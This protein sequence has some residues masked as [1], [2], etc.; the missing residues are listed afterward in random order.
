ML[1]QSV[2]RDGQQRS[3][4]HSH[5]ESALD[6]LAE[7]APPTTPLGIGG[8]SR[9]SGGG[10][11]GGGSGGCSGSDAALVLWDF[12]DLGDVSLSKRST[13]TRGGPANRLQ[14]PRENHMS[15]PSDQVACKT[16]RGA[17]VP[18][19]AADAPARRAAA[20]RDVGPPVQKHPPAVVA[21]S[22]E[23]ESLGTKHGGSSGA[24]AQQTHGSAINVTTAAQ[25]GLS[26]AAT[27][28]AAGTGASLTLWQFLSEQYDAPGSAVLD[29]RTVVRKSSVDEE[30]TGQATTDGGTAARSGNGGGG[31]GDEL[32]MRAVT[33]NKA[34]RR[35]KHRGKL[36]AS[37]RDRGYSLA[38]GPVNLASP[39]APPTARAPNGVVEATAISSM[40]TAAA[41][42][43]LSV[44]APEF[45]PRVVQPA[46]PVPTVVTD[47][48]WET[49]AHSAGGRGAAT[50]AINAARVA[51]TLGGGSGGR[52]RNSGNDGGASGGGSNRS[53]GGDFVRSERR[54]GE[55]GR[56]GRG[57]RDRRGMGARG[58]TG[59]EYRSS[60][61]RPVHVSVGKDNGTSHDAGRANQSTANTS[62]GTRSYPTN[63]R[64]GGHHPNRQA[65]GGPTS[66]AAIKV[67]AEVDI[68]LKADQRTGALTR[69]VVR[70]VLTNSS[71]HPRGIKV[72]LS[73]GAV[74]RVDTIYPPRTKNGSNN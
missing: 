23:G 60:L 62:I 8:S 12:L 20:A 36:S 35:S 59:E 48:P 67:G 64:V 9:E 68:V 63:R 6:P 65:G 55:R 53:G 44:A 56:R 50:W 38:S 26:A 14:R 43:A 69:G 73:S 72:R 42:D 7:S 46:T 71:T 40:S 11:S 3:R 10:G 31:G 61:S 2:E 58:R 33:T 18:A 54:G 27:A 21:A 32:A 5:T 34:N 41:Y 4:Y 25:V 16:A 70:E 37:G 57:A 45:V 28:H 13:P 22:N 1:P 49:P 15:A 74:G 39:A 29:G 52:D 30:T 19:R 51:H 17:N 47:G 66:R 24:V